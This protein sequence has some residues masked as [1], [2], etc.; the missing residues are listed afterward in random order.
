MIYIYRET[1]EECGGEVVKFCEKVMKMV[2]KSLGLEEEYMKRVFGG[3]GDEGVGVT[4]RA[5]YYPRCPQ[6]ELTLGLSPHSDP[7]GVTVLLADERVQ[8][9]QVHKDGAWVTVQPLPH[10]FI[11]NLGDQIQVTFFLTLFAF[12]FFIFK[13]SWCVFY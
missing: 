12:Y 5:N 2:S 4:M 11:V 1:V 7:G 6:P 10:A 8:G 3:Y 13:D 9:L